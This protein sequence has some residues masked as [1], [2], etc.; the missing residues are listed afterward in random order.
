MKHYLS[1]NDK[2]KR[3]GIY[4][5]GIPAFKDMA[6]NFT[7]PNAAKCAIGCYARQGRY[8]MP[9]VKNA[10]ETRLA[11]T[12]SPEFVATINSEIQKRK[13]IKIV[14][15][16]DSGDFYDISYFD[17]WLKI[18]IANPKIK[19]Y[20]YTKMISMVKLYTKGATLPKN[21][22]IIFSFGGKQDAL[23]DT[24]KDSHSKVFSSLGE[25]KRNGY[26]DVTK[27]DIKAIKAL[28][29]GLVYHGFKSRTWS[30]EPK[31]GQNQN[32]LTPKQSNNK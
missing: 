26:T 16:H 11:L 29:V 31:Q 28:K 20:A 4:S 15:I 7:C 22:K 18:A 32:V 6:G 30:T 17:D 23:I 21:I 24:A 13:G 8:A 2:L 9:N 14:R 1:T 3:N 27:F 10:Q 12:K 19:F 25:L 5:F